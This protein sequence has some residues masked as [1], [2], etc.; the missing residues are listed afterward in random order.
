[1]C[2]D[3][4]SPSGRWI[5][6]MSKSWQLWWYNRLFALVSKLSN[7]DNDNIV[8][9]PFFIF[10]VSEF[11]SL[12]SDLFISINLTVKFN[13]KKWCSQRPCTSFLRCFLFIYFFILNS[14]RHLW[15]NLPLPSTVLYTLAVT[16]YPA[17]I[18][19]TVKQKERVG[20]RFFKIRK[21]KTKRKTERGESMK[22]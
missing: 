2:E 9:L 21:G 4:L 7:V 11:F 3:A 18:R 13:F 16:H 19:R 17:L 12:I 8:L 5:K 22:S 20:G 10:S 15:C 1:M 14:N 6:Q